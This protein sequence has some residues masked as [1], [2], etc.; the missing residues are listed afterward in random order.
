LRPQY[1]QELR[2]AEKIFFCESCGRILI[3]NPPVSLE[4][5]MH[6]KT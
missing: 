4:H 6:T 5:E 3:Y 2:H 1:F